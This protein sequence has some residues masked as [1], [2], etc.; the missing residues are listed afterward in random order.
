MN[1]VRHR[2]VTAMIAEHAERDPQRPAVV[3]IHED[4]VQRTATAGELHG[5]ALD[6]ARALHTHDVRADDLVLVALRYEWGLLPALFGALYIGA[7]PSIFPYLTD[8]LAPDAYGDRVGTLAQEAGA[9]AVVTTSDVVPRLRALLGESCRVLTCDDLTAGRGDS[10]V[11]PVQRA[12]DQTAL[13]QFTSGT[14]GRQKGVA[15][16]HRQLLEFFRVFVAATSLGPDD[17]V[18]S[19]LPI[20]HDMGLHTGLLIPLVERARTV[21][22]SPAYWVRN[23]VTMLRAVH[24]FKGTMSWMPNFAFNHCVQRVRDAD[25][26]GLDLRSWRINGNGAEPVRRESIDQ[27]VRRFAPYGVRPAAMKTAYGMAENVLT[28]TITHGDGP[29]RVDWIDGAALQAER[30]AVPVAADAAG[31]QSFVSCGRP[32]GATELR[33]VDTADRAVPERRIGEVVIRTPYSLRRYYRQPEASAAA[34]RD[35][36]LYTGDLGYLADGELYLCG[37][38]K[39][40]II[41]GGANVHP[42][43]VEFVAEAVA[44]VQPG[45]AVAFGVFDAALGTERVVLLCE[46]RAG[47]AD[48]EIHRTDRELRRLVQQRL[49]V[50]LGDLR[51]VEKG[52]IVKTTSGKLAR[53]ANRDKYR[54]EFGGGECA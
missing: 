52:W 8:R 50:T 5:E 41:V 17:V 1:T 38:K 16:S 24:E 37:R 47:L 9:R 2:T 54:A 14:T 36:W 27:F 21:M 28:I 43:E 39:D 15:L 40:V 53:A 45:R 51:F 12:P 25:L 18:V 31:A 26:E 13:I 6:A 19:W 29:P 35:G 42:E 10:P 44:A 34:V 11:F 33:I 7:V 22:M 32:L 48:Q 23:P 20:N 4:G 3:F 30:R 46:L 49:D